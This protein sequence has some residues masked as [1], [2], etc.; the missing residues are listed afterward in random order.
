MMP[1]TDHKWSAWKL[2]CKHNQQLFSQARNTSS[3]QFLHF[4][5]KNYWPIEYLYII[6][7]VQ[8]LEFEIL[9]II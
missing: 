3:T 6:N 5:M 9:E 8:L 1:H 7:Y 4:E 2:Y